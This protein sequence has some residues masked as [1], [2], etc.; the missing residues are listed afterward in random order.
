MVEMIRSR[1]ID[2]SIVEHEVAKRETSTP[3]SPASA[4][5]TA[6]SATT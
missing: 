4:P 3:Q 2:L 6:A 1:T 5:A